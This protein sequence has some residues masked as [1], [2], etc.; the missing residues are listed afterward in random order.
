MDLQL[1]NKV[2]VITGGASGIGAAI[3]ESCA[4]EGAIPV[5]VNRDT[6]DARSFVERLRGAG[7]RCELVI[8]ELLEPESC[9]QAVVEALRRC[10]RIDA[11]VNNA[12]FND[13]AGLENG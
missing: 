12:G 2:V 7:R 10:G 4:A 3:S 8:A 1:K 5:I 6:E 13:G 9:K 11:L